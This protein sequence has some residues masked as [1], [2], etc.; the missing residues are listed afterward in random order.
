MNSR[1]KIDK[2]VTDISG[3]QVDPKTPPSGPK[4]GGKPYAAKGGEKVFKMKGADNGPGFAQK[5]N[6]KLV[7]KPKED[8]KKSSAEGFAQKGDKKLIYKPKDNPKKVKV[9]TVESRHGLLPL[10]R[11]SLNADPCFVQYVINEMRD[12]DLMGVLVGELLDRRE[13]YQHIAEVMSHPV[14]GPRVC[15]KLIQALAEETSEPLHKAGVVHENPGDPGTEQPA[16]DEAPQEEEDPNAQDPNAQ[17]PN[18]QDPNAPAQ[19]PNAQ[20]AAPQQAPPPPG[21]MNLQQAM[22]RKF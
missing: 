2:P 10:L 5:G 12:G 11:E 16:E 7:Y 18:A 20:G 13:T 17:D 19:D 22:M 4:G 9:P 8:G 21:M 3:D 14:Y 15:R 6:Q 1:G